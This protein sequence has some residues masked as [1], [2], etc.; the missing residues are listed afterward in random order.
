MPGELLSD[1]LPLP[2]FFCQ[3]CS[4][5]KPKY[6]DYRFLAFT[7]LPFLFMMM[8]RIIIILFTVDMITIFCSPPAGEW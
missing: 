5:G 2:S 8:K 4:T 7:H 6:L 1:V 3:L